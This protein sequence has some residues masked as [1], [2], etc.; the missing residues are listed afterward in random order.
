MFKG[1]LDRFRKAREPLTDAELAE[2]EQIR[3]EAEQERR[4]AEA[5]MAQQRQRIDS[6]G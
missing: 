2:Q 5:A 1:L 4:R 3:R 6:G